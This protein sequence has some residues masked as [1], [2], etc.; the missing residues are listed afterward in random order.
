MYPVVRFDHPTRD[1]AEPAAPRTT[2]WLRPLF[3]DP[4][5]WIE[6]EGAEQ[7]KLQNKRYIPQN[8]AQVAEF[9]TSSTY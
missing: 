9:W 2:F 5:G 8:R 4:A 6:E 3:F 1:R 7:T